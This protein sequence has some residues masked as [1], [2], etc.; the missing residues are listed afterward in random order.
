M[1]VARSQ[2]GRMSSVCPLPA[3]VWVQLATTGYR[4]ER[5]ASLD[6]SLLGMNAYVSLAYRPCNRADWRNSPVLKKTFLS[7][8]ANFE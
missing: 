5:L 8:S 7:T 6:K 2:R 3:T 1:V 4:L